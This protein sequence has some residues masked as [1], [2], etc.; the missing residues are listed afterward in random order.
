MTH[1]V[2]PLNKNAVIEML[3]KEKVSQGGI[4]LTRNDPNEVTKARVL[5]VGVNCQYIKVGD[6]IMP[7]WNAAIKS[8]QTKTNA[9][10]DTFFI[11]NEDEVVMIFD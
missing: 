11:I 1:F 2:K 4:V 6:I 8:E 10:D 5:A 3:D 9:L 7:N